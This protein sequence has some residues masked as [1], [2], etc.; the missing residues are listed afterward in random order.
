MHSILYIKLS[1][2]E[3]EL[4]QGKH[5]IQKVTLP[6]CHRSSRQFHVR[7]YSHTTNNFL[8]IQPPQLHNNFS[9]LV[10]WL[11]CGLGFIECVFTPFRY[12][13]TDD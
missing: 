10:W 1:D 13:K 6:N 9:H 7:S 8:Q 12:M 11:I 3:P 4:L 2:D 5:C